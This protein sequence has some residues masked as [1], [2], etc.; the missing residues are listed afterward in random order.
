MELFELLGIAPPILEVAFATPSVKTYELEA[1]LHATGTFEMA[2]YTEP[3]ASFPYVCLRFFISLLPLTIT[4]QLNI[5]CL[6][7]DRLEAILR[8]ELKTK[9]ECEIELGTELISFEQDTEAEAVDV[10]I[11]NK[12]GDVENARYDWLLGADG[13]RGVVRRQLGVSFLGETSN[14]D[15]IVVGDVLIQ[16]LDQDVSLCGPVIFHSILKPLSSG[17]CGATQ[18]TYCT[19]GIVLTVHQE[20]LTILLQDQ[21]PADGSALPLQFHRGWQRHRKCDNVVRS[22]RYPEN[23]R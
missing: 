11:K 15:Q 22:G 17:I 4:S 13:A 14:V 16:G 23:V 21:F 19:I 7:Q 9:Y 1:G 8:N 12:S 18:R 20:G 2:P 3:T 6:G 10:K 5:L